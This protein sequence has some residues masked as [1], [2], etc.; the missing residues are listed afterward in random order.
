MKKT[1][2]VLLLFAFAL[3]AC[4]TDEKLDDTVDLDS[5]E[6]LSKEVEKVWNEG[7][8]EGFMTLIDDEAIFKGPDNS[9][10][11]GIEALRDFYNGFFNT[12]SFDVEIISEEIFVFGDYAYS[13][14]IW[15]GSMTPKDGSA[16]IEFDNTDMSIYKKQADGTWKFWRVMYNSNSPATE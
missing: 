15:T 8:F 2:I 14:E 12:L 5:L 9:S 1:K 3:F 16:P 13:L 4:S 10:V 6:S 7:D 11:V